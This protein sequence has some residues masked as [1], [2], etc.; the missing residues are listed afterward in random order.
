MGILSRPPRAFRR[1]QSHLL[2]THLGHPGTALGIGPRGSTP[3]ATPKLPCTSQVPGDFTFDKTLLDP[4]LFFFLFFFI[5]GYS[6]MAQEQ[7]GPRPASARHTPPIPGNGLAETRWPSLALARMRAAKP[8]SSPRLSVQDL[9]IQGCTPPWRL[10][11]P[12]PLLSTPPGL[13]TPQ[14]PYALTA[15]EP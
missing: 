7:K 10:A 14:F 4:S 15:V 2:A 5:K 1:R 8:S 12:D 11:P 6:Y 3:G 9:E 13:S